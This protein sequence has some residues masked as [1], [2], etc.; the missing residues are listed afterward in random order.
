LIKKEVLLLLAMTEAV[1][2]I[3]QAITILSC[4]P[5]EHELFLMLH[6]RSSLFP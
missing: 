1:F 6:F 3:F 4:I 2:G 5:E